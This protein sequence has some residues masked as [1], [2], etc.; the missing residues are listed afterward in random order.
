MAT[1]LANRVNSTLIVTLLSNE[2][3]W[4]AEL[5]YEGINPLVVST[6]IPV[7]SR[8]DKKLVV[9]THYEVIT[10]HVG[11]KSNTIHHNITLYSLNVCS[12]GQARKTDKRMTLFD[13][14]WDRI[15]LDEG[16]AIKNK[17]TK[18][19][20]AMCTLASDTTIKWILSAT[21][22][23]NKKEELMA[24]SKWIGFTVSKRMY[25]QC[26]SAGFLSDATAATLHR[27]QLRWWPRSMYCDAAVP[28]WSSTAQRWQCLMPS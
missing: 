9:L 16:H 27:N 20:Q 21:P 10:A 22:M 6:T 1:M 5:E 24:I 23:Q 13:R 14:K 3:Y 2:D 15:I 12:C 28:R 4:R 7:P 18:L 26:T 19:H 8:E 25:K 17:S 11:D